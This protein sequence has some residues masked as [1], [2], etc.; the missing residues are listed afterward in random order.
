MIRK[1]KQFNDF[2]F[3]QAEQRYLSSLVEDNFDGTAV[4]ML[5]GI[6]NKLSKVLGKGIEMKLKGWY[7][8]ASLQ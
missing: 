6:W 8:D 7:R 2:L 4:V 5:N 3:H 1:R